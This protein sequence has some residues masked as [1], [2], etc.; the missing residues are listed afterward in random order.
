MQ[1]R[2]VLRGLFTAG[3]MVFVLNGAGAGGTQEEVQ[4]EPAPAAESEPRTVTVNTGELPSEPPVPAKDLPA[5]FLDQAPPGRAAG[6]FTTDFSRATVSYADVISGGPSKGGIPAIDR[7]QFETVDQASEWIADREPVL[8]LESSLVRDGESPGGDSIHVYPLQVIMWHEIVNDV[9]DGKPVTVTYCPLCNTG[10]AFSRR[11]EGAVLSFNTTGRLRFSNLIMFDR[12]TESWWQQ[13]SGD[14]VAG[15]FAGTRLTP[16]PVMML[17]FSEVRE[18]M[19][20]ARVL[21]KETGFSRNYGGNPYRGYDSSSEPFL[22]RNAEGLAG[23]S[24]DAPALLDRVVSLEHNAETTSVTYTALEE[25]LVVERTL[26]GERFYFLWEAGTASALDSSSIAEGADVGSGN[27]FFASTRGGD[28]V[29]LRR[30]GDR[31]VDESG[32]RWNAAGRAVSGPREGERLRPA[33]GVQ[34]FW[35]SHAALVAREE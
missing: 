34:H 33:V 1:G 19:P 11:H 35:F 7:P 24:A 15:F 16:V 9:I 8:V 25:E 30:R 23:T 28:S 31:I 29:E 14:A 32:S 26:G 13:A 27:A 20:E 6:E 21:S 12:E 17:P 3:I 22:L 10:I 18:S 2:R 5:A 4:S